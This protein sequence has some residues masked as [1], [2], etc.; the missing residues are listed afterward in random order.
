MHL[1]LLIIALAT[2]YLTRLISQFPGIKYH[3][4]WGL[5]LFFFIFPPLILL[6]TCLTVTLMGYQGEM[7][8]LKASRFSY[9]LAFSYVLIAVF[10]LLISFVNLHKLGQLIKQYPSQTIGEQTIKILPSSFPYAAQVGFWRSQLVL[11]TGLLKLLPQ[12]HLNAVIAHE[13]AHQTHKD[14][15]FFFWLSYLERLTFWLPNNRSLWHNL[16]LLRELRADQTAAET[17]DFLL[18]AESLITVT[19]ATAKQKE[20]LDLAW[21]CPFN[22]N[23]LEERINNLLEENNSYQFNWT[24]IIWLIFIFIPYSFLPFHIHS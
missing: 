15:F 19:S 5:S 2:A 20:S 22:D 18:I 23:R 16:L 13:N 11:S 17:V 24:Q 1:V 10:N 6:M 21:Q 3:K 8:G 12:E 9:Y 4:K 7:W 14:P